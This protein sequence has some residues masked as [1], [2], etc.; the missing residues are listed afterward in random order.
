ML[1]KIRQHLPYTDTTQIHKRTNIDKS[2]NQLTPSILI[3]YI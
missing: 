1:N 2:H 3:L